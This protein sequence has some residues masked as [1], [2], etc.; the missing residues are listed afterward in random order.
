MDINW[1]E[2]GWLLVLAAVI[3]GQ[4]AL[5]LRFILREGKI[6]KRVTRLERGRG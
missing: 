6:E 4:W 5:N 3:L 1:R 2:L